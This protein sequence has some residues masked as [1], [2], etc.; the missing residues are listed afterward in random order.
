VCGVFGILG[1]PDSGYAISKFFQDLM[2]AS[3]SRGKDASGVLIASN[4][5]IEILK[6]Q[7]RGKHLLAEKTTKKALRALDKEFSSGEIRLLAGHTRM[8]THGDINDQG[9]NQPVMDG[10][11]FIILH[12]GIITNWKTLANDLKISE[13]QKFSDTRIFSLLLES[14]CKF[15]LDARQEIEKFAMNTEG[16]NNFI[17]LDK[18]KSELY[19]YT[20]NGSLFYG[21]DSKKKFFY[22]ASEKKIILNLL[23]KRDR[24]SITQIS[25]MKLFVVS[26]FLAPELA[27]DFKKSILEGKFLNVNDIV[28][29]TFV[30]MPIEISQSEVTL[31]EV[32]HLTSSV[33]RLKIAKLMRCKK[34]I[35][36]I[37]FPGIEFD[38][39]GICSLCRDSMKNIGKNQNDIQDLIDKCGDRVLVPL[40]GGRDSSFALH[41]IVKELNIPAIAYTYDWGLISNV[42]REN[43]SRMCGTLGVEHILIAADIRRKRKNV[44][45][46]LL[47]WL[48]KPNIGM[49]P[50]LMA[51]DKQFLTLAEKVRRENKL[52]VSVF[53]MNSFERTLFK[54]AYAGA[55][56]NEDSKRSHGITRLGQLRMLKYY[57]SKILANRK[58][59]NQSLLDSLTGFFSFYFVKPNYIQLFDFIDWNE[60]E[61]MNV[62]SRDYGWEAD[63]TAHNSW[64][65]G[66]ATSGFYNYLYLK[67]GGFT[68]NDTFRSNQI[69]SGAISRSV[70]L[71]KIEQENEIQQ[72]MILE[73]LK[74]ID[75]DLRLVNEKLINWGYFRAT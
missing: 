74:V 66:D 3:E 16:A 1:L 14:K 40:S 70:A 8:M 25:K 43:I 18:R 15:L 24:L 20:S 26:D 57:G 58:Y 72:D 75:V 67:F 36:P 7:H 32:T 52:A 59:W 50:I 13:P 35:L 2:T 44:K 17:I 71:R 69:R 29:T 5:E 45:S 38:Q 6:S 31:S 9:N 4:R 63:A 22:F 34:C 62:L 27:N 56:L 41:Y 65:M 10:E 21:I 53:A 51:G 68:E 37:T 54:S 61:I 12:N 47:A 33:S 60:D 46:N 42:A 19:F 23:R 55:P 28:K 49:I 73:Y 30:D 48:D 64:R 11:R 39:N